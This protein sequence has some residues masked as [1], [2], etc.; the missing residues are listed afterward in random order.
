MTTPSTAL[1]DLQQAGK[2]YRRAGQS[3]RAL[4]DFSLR[5][6]A[7]EI[8]GLLGPNGS[9]KT[10]LVKLV[11]GLCGA[12]Q[13]QLRW[14]GG[15]A[16]PAGQAGPHLREIGVILEGRGAAYERLST[17]ENARY[18][19]G[20]REARFDRAHFDQLAALLEIPDVRAP[21]RQFSTGNKLRAALLGALIHKPAL[22]LL[23]EPTLGLDLLGVERL[24]AL[25]RH[26]AQQGMAFVLSSHDLHFIE[27]LCGR[28]VCIAQGR[29][30]FD[31]PR[32]SFVQLEHHYQLR[33]QPPAGEAPPALPLALAG[34]RWQAPDTTGHGDGSWTLPLRSHAETCLLLTAWQ[35]ELPRCRGLE[36]RRVDLRDHYLGLV[37]ADASRAEPQLEGEAA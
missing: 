25:V 12:D 3:I 36:L 35:H 31:G 32:Q 13:G 4:D 11:T 10:T 14:R 26:G 19:C 33:L 20:L 30:V 24:Q 29:K 1:L 17:L 8:V 28:I 37:G 21:V 27:R 2:T 22:A 7:G 15:D 34:L 9:G 5:V 18:F 23:D 16:L 6:Q